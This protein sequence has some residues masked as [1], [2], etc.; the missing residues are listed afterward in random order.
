MYN[1]AVVEDDL[2]MLNYIKELIDNEEYILELYSDPLKLV[3]SI[4]NKVYDIVITDLKMPNLS[5]LDVLEYVKKISKDT[6]VIL[7]TAHGTIESAIESI[8]KGAYDYILKPFE[9]EQL[10]I[11][12]KRASELINLNRENKRLNEIISSYQEDIFIGDN[13]EVKKIK[14]L[15]HKIARTDVNLLIQGETGTGKGLVAKL[16]HKYSQRKDKNF[17]AV[18]CGS[19]SEHLLESEL[20]GHEKGAFTGAA[21]QRKGLFETYN[22]GTI[23]LDEINSTSLNFQTKMLKVIEEKKIMRVGLSKEIEVDV[24]IIAASNAPIEEEIK[25]GNFRKDLYYR[26]SVFTV[27][28]PPLRDRPEDILL[29][30]KYFLTKKS[31]V[32][33]KK[34]D[35]FSEQITDKLIN[36]NWPGNVRELENTIERAVILETPPRIENIEFS[37]SDQIINTQNMNVPIMKLEQMEELL[38]EKVMKVHKNRNKAAEILGIDPTTLWRKLKKL[39]VEE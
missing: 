14:E 4:D 27:N 36:H 30:S 19:I 16:I 25:K 20:F 6:V 33:G 28:I 34:F 21:T 31:S 23:F 22:K 15:I 12:L 37:S 10:M 39:N 7:I 18:N 26:L 3:G 13:A 11:V 9:P 32:Y 8:K 2:S 29:L 5:G 38:I 17:I 35:G 1:V 24:R